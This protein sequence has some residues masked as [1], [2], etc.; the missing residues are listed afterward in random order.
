MGSVVELGGDPG[1][2][3][4]WVGPVQHV[5]A[6]SGPRQQ[7]LAAH[8]PAGWLSSRVCDERATSTSPQPF[9]LIGVLVVFNELETAHQIVS[10]EILGRLLKDLSLPGRA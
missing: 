5:Y 8:G 9:D 2:A 3:H 4:G 10:P 7:P 1:C 6:L